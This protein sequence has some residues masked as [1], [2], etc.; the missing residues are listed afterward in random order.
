MKRI[1]AWL[2][3]AAAALGLAAGLGAAPAT[4]TYFGITSAIDRIDASLKNLPA[5]QNPHGAEWTRFFDDIRNDLRLYTA[6]PSVGE[7]VK[8]LQ[9]LYEKSNDLAN[10]PWATAAELRGEIR[11][12]LRPRIA[13]AW[14]EYRLLESIKDLPDESAATRDGWRAFVSDRLR[15]AQHDLEAADT[16]SNRLDALDRVH[17][18][19]E[20]LQ[21]SA[22]TSPWSRTMELQS[23]VADL[24]SVPDVEVAVDQSALT[25]AVMQQGI[26]EPG[27]I[28]FKGQWSY[29]T[30]G[31]LTGLGF[32]PTADGIMVSISQALNSTTPIQ[33]FQQQ[34]AQDP[35]GRRAANLYHFDATTNN[36]AV[37]T[38]TILFRL[39]TGVSI[40]PGYQHGISATINSL[41]QQGKGLGRFVAS[42][43]GYNQNNITERVY[44]GAIGQIRQQVVES[45]GELAGIKASQKADQINAQIRPYVVDGQTIATRDFGLTGLSLQT[46]PNYARIQ[47]T[48]YS[49]AAGGVFGSMF[50]QPG[51]F[52]SLQQG[53]TVDVNLSSTISSLSRGYF[54]GA[55]ARDV[56]NVMIVT[57]KNL[58]DPKH[59]GIDITQNVDWPTYLARVQQSRAQGDAE[60]QAIR[61]YKPEKSPLAAADANGRLVL[62]LPDFTM[63]VPAPPM[64]ARGGAFTGPPAQV[65]RVQ[66]RRAEVV[67]DFKLQPYT[68]PEP[69][70]VVGQVADFDPGGNV[71]VWAIND[72]DTKPAPLN[73]FSAGIVGTTVAGRVRG[74]PFDVPLEQ[75]RGRGLELTYASALDPSGWLR[76]V[77]LPR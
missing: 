18:A 42:L 6:S 63:E 77:V 59:P 50:P 5:G 73:A 48:L 39:A 11:S 32:V 9:R 2:L 47:G 51:S 46:Y 57:T 69:P 27:W 15:A 55:M 19:F 4:P 66:F 1:R 54:Q 12:W 23:A 74:L 22:R 49:Q 26:V 72:D 34:V 70:H 61:V 43:I 44:E 71:Q 25:T 37:L 58:D 20:A 41:P 60:A 13:L 8:A 10:V 52:Q 24:Y 38:T 7:R 29:V 62:Y 36:S 75:L 65:Y 28:F 3:I 35:Q 45:A 64:A 67:L 30:P 33:G 31:P 16:V 53:L 21:K 40:A 17:S 76:L 14:A 56:E 68:Y